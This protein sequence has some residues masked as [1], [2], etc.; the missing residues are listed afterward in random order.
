MALTLGKNINAYILQVA[1]TLTNKV[2]QVKVFNII[3]IYILKL[4]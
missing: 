2:M 1:K 3:I 4:Q